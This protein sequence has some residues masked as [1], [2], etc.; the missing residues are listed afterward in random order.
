MAKEDPQS[1]NAP[2]IFPNLVPGLLCSSWVGEGNL[3]FISID[4][5][6]ALPGGDGDLP[7]LI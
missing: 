3:C 1:L 4:L 2:V 6:Q 7:N 5:H